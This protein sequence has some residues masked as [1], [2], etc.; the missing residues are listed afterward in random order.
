M[1]NPYDESNLVPLGKTLNSIDTGNSKLAEVEKPIAVGLSWN[2]WV[3]SVQWLSV[4]FTKGEDAPS[5]WSE[6]YIKAM[7]ADLQYY[8]YEDIQKALIKLHGE[9]RSYAPNSSQII[10]MCN[11]LGLRQVTSAAQAERAAKGQYSECRGG[12][13]HNFVDWGWEYDE[14]GRP[15]FTEWCLNT[16]SIDTP[17]CYAER[18]KGESTL[19][20]QQKNMKPKPMTRERFIFTMDKLMGLPKKQ[21]DELLKYRNKLQTNADIGE[22]E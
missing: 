14:V 15:I 17:P 5:E 21:Q 7:F 16:Y 6:T 2:D 13:N 11:K 10:G 9:G 18:T 20:E 1:D 22:E 8:T 3:E 12:A 19:T 4:R